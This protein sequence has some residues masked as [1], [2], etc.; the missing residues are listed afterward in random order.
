[1]QTDEI[2]DGASR[3]GPTRPI[4]A[5][6]VRDAHLRGAGPRPSR[7][8]WPSRGSCG[9]IRLCDCVYVMCACG[10]RGHGQ[11]LEKLQ[12]MR[13]G[14]TVAAGAAVSWAGA[15]AWSETGQRMGTACS[16]RACL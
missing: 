1:M 10:S 14:G 6:R 15:P 11:G 16:P 4:L 7:R 12:G 9:K 5:P 8:R 2:Q 3:Q 13:K